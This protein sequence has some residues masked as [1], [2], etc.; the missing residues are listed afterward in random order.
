MPT[1]EWPG[2]VVLLDGGLRSPED[3]LLLVDDNGVVRGD[4]IFETLV[5]RDGDPV[6]F[7]AHLDRMRRS[8]A[9]ADLDLPD[10]QQWRDAVAT[11]LAETP[12]GYDELMLRLICTRGPAGGRPTAFVRTNPLAAST[13]VQRR[14]GVS[15]VLLDRGIDAGRVAASPW[16][17]GAA[18]TLSY[19]VAMAALREAERRGAD[20][21]IYTDGDGRLLEAPTASVV[22]VGPGNRM[23]TP[24]A[25]GAILP[26][27]TQH[28]LF[29]A[30]AAAGW[31]TSTEPLYAQDLFDADAVWL[32]SSVRIAVAVTEVDGTV[33]KQSVP[34]E[35]AQE[36]LGLS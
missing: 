33:I 15:V 26:S 28:A 9:Y 10:E 13:L 32:V 1:S 12:P 31:E 6:G 30:A 24:A 16:L 34:V 17:L 7:R 21:V 3:P 20:D 18:K 11:A 29:D 14:D 27:T 25:E 19:A 2:V 4:G 35:T 36:M 5:V 22:V 23:R 8:A